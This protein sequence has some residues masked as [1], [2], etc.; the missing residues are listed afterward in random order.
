[1]VQMGFA[2]IAASGLYQASFL[3]GVLIDWSGRFKILSILG[4]RAVQSWR[5]AQT[6][7]GG[8][9]AFVERTADPYKSAY[10]GSTLGDI[11]RV[12]EDAFG[13]G[14]F[15]QMASRPAWARQGS[16]AD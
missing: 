12:H 2:S 8:L 1:M 14:M 4:A 11:M 13:T 15:G 6:P 10:E 7:F 3:T 5:A 16:T 9:S